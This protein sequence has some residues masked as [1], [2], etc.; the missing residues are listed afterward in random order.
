MNEP[1]ESPDIRIELKA[2]RDKSVRNHHPWIFSGAIAKTEGEIPP[3]GIVP[4][5]GSDGDFL[6]KGIW[7]AASQIRLRLLTFKNEPVDE[8][9]FQKRIAKAL[10]LRQQFIAADTNAFRLIHAEGDNLPGLI[11]DRYNHTLVMQLYSTGMVRLRDLLVEQLSAL[12]GIEHIYERSDGG[13][14]REEKLPTAVAARHGNPPATLGITEN[15]IPFKI[16]LVGGQKTGFFLDQRDNRAW[17]GRH[18]A[19]GRLLNCFSYS[20]G[21]SVYAARGGAQ[22]VSVD[23]SKPG[24]DLARENFERSEL[25]PAGHQFVQE[26]VFEYLRKADDGFDTIILDPPAFVK[27]RR[28][29]TKGSRAY[30]DI[31]RL[32]MQKIRDGGTLLTCSCSHFADR[33]L[34]RQIIFS[35]AK[36]AGRTAQIIAQPG[37]PADHP[38]N[39]FHPEGEYL[40][41]LI[42]RITD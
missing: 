17:I 4:V 9:F 31:N 40:K 33:T 7:N 12:S 30:K 6:A 25:D 18:A 35:A 3:G 22:T 42:L 21:F 41:T 29:I 10:A 15:G 27:H 26:N 39:I 5:Y 19:N 20:G 32:A 13:A 24:I 16:D 8:A 36:E 37:Q 2:G 23:S 34:F 11:V 14:L 1:I 28:D 38:V